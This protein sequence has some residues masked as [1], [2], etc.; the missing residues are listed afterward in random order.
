MLCVAADYI[1][2][3]EDRLST[4]RGSIVPGKASVQ[5]MLRWTA[6]FC[7]AMEHA[8]DRGLIAHR[9]IKPENL[10]LGANVK[11]LVTN[12]AISKAAALDWVRAAENRHEFKAL[13]SS[14]PAYIDPEQWRGEQQDFRK[15]AYAFAVVLHELSFMRL[16]WAASSIS[17]LRVAHLTSTINVPDHPLAATIKRA[18]SKNPADRFTSPQELLDHLRGVSKKLGIP[19]PPRP[20]PVQISRDDLMAE[21]SLGHFERNL[22]RATAAAQLVTEKWPSYSPGWTQLGRLRHQQNDL[23]EAREATERSLKIDPTHSAPRNNLGIINKEEGKFAEAVT[24]ASRVFRRLL[25]VRRSYDE[26]RKE[27]V[28]T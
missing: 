27:Q 15:D 1:S 19:L 9:D 6:E 7:Y 11:L 3:Q 26:Q 16:P 25:S 4:I 22:N 21:A 12:F 8:V 2:P 20:L 13:T 10:L 17:Q 18:L 28:F 24:K 5:E 14:T 23:T